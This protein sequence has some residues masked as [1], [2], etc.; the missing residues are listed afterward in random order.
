[1]SWGYDADNGPATWHKAFPIANGKRQSP[2]DI[3]PGNATFDSKLAGA[4]LVIKYKPETKLQAKNNGKTM[5]VHETQQSEIS[6]GPLTG[7]YRF[8]QF[9]FHWGTDDK[10]GS[11]HTVNGKLYASELHLVHYNSSKYTSFA[12]AVDKPDGL[13]IFAFFIKLGAKHAGMQQLTDSTISNIQEEGQSCDLPGFKLA[14]LLCSDM[15]KYW[16]YEGSLTNPPLH[17]SATWIVFKEPVEMSAD[18][19]HAL[20][21]LKGG[22]KCILVNRRPVVPLGDRTVRASFK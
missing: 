5:T 2:I 16:A 19:L 4:P 7:T 9:H 13:G 22:S 6:G 14:S 8:E 18:Q 10:E 11:E 3:V 15:S 20:R 21:T 17:E 12:E 1:M